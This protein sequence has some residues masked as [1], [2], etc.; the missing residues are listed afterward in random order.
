MFAVPPNTIALSSTPATAHP[1]LIARQLAADTH[2]W[3]HLLRF[4]TG[5]RFTT[6]V[7]ESEHQ[8]VW[9]M[10]WLPGQGTDLHNHGGATGAF[11]VVEG[12]LTE[13]VA[14]DAGTQR[15]AHSVHRVESGQSRVFGPGY[16]HRVANDGPEPAVSIH[17][18]RPA[19]LPMINYRLRAG[20]LDRV[21]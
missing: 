13:S 21:L 7:E 18:Y 1:A 4:H 19:R 11:T 16:V 15:P 14:R 3:R 6:L 5:E 8:E 2:R 17:V 20:G 10:S 12:V 9:L